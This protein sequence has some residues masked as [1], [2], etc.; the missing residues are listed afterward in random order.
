MVVCAA[1][2]DWRQASRF[3]A[4]ALGDA[5]LKSFQDIL[6]QKAVEPI[7]VYWTSPD[8]ANLRS[9]LRGLKAA[10]SDVVDLLREP[11]RSPGS[12]ATW[13]NGWRDAAKSHQRCF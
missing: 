4:T 10:T 6:R 1:R 3:A 11:G 13:Q 9:L 5:E 12:R 8:Y 7:V 2:S